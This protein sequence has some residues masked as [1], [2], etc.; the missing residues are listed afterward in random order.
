MNIIDA[1]VVKFSA[2]TKDLDRG[3]EKAGERVDKFGQASD[4]QAKHVNN[5]SKKMAEGFRSVRTEVAGLLSLSLGAA[6]IG[7]LMS[8]TIGDQS[9]LG[10]LSQ[11]LKLSAR[12]LDAWG[13]VM[14]QVGGKAE[15]AQQ[16]MQNIA[17]AITDRSL[18]ID[19][20]GASTLYNLGIAMADR[21]GNRRAPQD[22][23]KELAG[24]QKFQNSDSQQQLRIGQMLGISDS[25][26]YL[27]RQGPQAFEKQLREAIRN[28]NVTDNS[29]KQAEQAQRTFNELGQSINGVWQTI[30]VAAAPA[31]EE[32]NHLL[33][34][35]G[36]WLTNNRSEIESFFT[37]FVDGTSDLLGEL[38]E[39]NRSTDGLAGK[40]LAAAA[41]LG[42]LKVGLGALSTV[43]GMGKGGGKGGG[44]AGMA[45]AAALGIPLAAE[46]AEKADAWLDTTTFG[47]WLNDQMRDSRTPFE[48]ARDTFNGRPEGERRDEGEL[49]AT[50]KLERKLDEIIQ[51]GRTPFEAARDAVKAVKDRVD[52]MQ[53]WKN[54]GNSEEAI[55]FFM[56]KGWTQAQAAGIAANLQHESNFDPTAVGDGGRAYGIAQWHP[57]RQ[58]EFAKEYGKHITRSSF[59]EQ[60]EFIQ[61]ELT[62]GNER[63]AGNA[64]RATNAAREAGAVVSKRYERPADREGE[65]NRRAQTSLVMNDMYD[66]GR[67]DFGNGWSVERD[68]ILDVENAHF[69]SV[70]RRE[71][72]EAQ[73]DNGLARFGSMI[74]GALRSLNESIRLPDNG[75]PVPYTQGMAVGAGAS[76]SITNNTS[77]SVSNNRSD[78]SIGTINV[79]TAATDADGI[80]RDMG[81]GI[82][83]NP[84]LDYSAMGMS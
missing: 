18:G 17:T 73:R 64:L 24:N 54:R 34:Q 21:E 53:S 25:M 72:G 68:Q 2:D 4:R 1:L 52:E 83:S 16:S 78:T 6:G 66:P 47:K 62:K 9:S 39:F 11:N 75:A 42:V 43:T 67:S 27:L 45:L 69:D 40:L 29:V 44:K 22:I 19:N 74:S 7:S 77:R 81:N 10:R 55:Q 82:R 28:S 60:L 70:V 37:G 41:A 59:R 84:L 63:K 38:N 33:Q 48:L 13:R 35:F 61:H 3:F 79:H 26:V 50:E 5:N 57:D 8:R 14:G 12:E 71:A 49:S 32:L 15:D 36:N 51:G 20:Q 58:A 46:G 76:P 65:A 80:A 30:F 23:I 56:D 31:M